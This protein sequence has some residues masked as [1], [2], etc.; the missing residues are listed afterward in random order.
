MRPVIRGNCPV[1]EDGNEIVFSKYSRARRYLINSIGEYCS[2]C[3][4]KIEVNLAVEHVIPKDSRPELTLVWSNF[5]LGCTNCNST[6]GDKPIVL[7]QYFWPDTDNTFNVFAYDNSGI[8]KVSKN[9][10]KAIDIEKAKN[11]IELVGL[12][13]RAEVVGSSAWEEA[14]D[15]R[16][17]HR[18]QAFFDSKELAVLYKKSGPNV[19]VI[20]KINIK[21]IVLSQGFWSIWMEAFKEFPEVQRMIIDAYPGTNPNYF[22]HIP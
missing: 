5:L 4:R 2:Y 22:V 18:L 20:L 6:K 9:L 21:I 1:D 15:R 11:M 13:S 7:T 3:E 8:V 17:E 16:F 14:S 12:D 10:K 19:R